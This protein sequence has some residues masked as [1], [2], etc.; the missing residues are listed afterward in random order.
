MSATQDIQMSAST[1]GIAKP[2]G[3]ASLANPNNIT[4]KPLPLRPKVA[5]SALYDKNP[6]RTRWER[7]QLRWLRPDTYPRTPNGM[8]VAEAGTSLL[9]SRA[10]ALGGSR[11]PGAGMA[12][13]RATAAR[14]GR[15]RLENYSSL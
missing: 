11:A 2:Q 3:N 5:D 9:P 7:F 13:E 6:I 1:Q 4:T 15:R 14:V 10:G 12:C 8:R